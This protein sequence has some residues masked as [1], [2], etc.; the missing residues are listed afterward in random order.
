MPFLPVLHRELIQTARRRHTYRIRVAAALVGIAM[1][2]WLL[3]VSAAQ[4][5]S[6]QQGRVLFSSLSSIAFACS[7]L[8]GIV[9]TADCISVEKR[10]GTLGLLFLTSLRGFDIVLGKLGSFSFTSFY[11]LLSI[12]PILAF[13]VLFGGISSGELIRTAAALL[14][15]LFFSL[16]T[17]LL[18]STLSRNERKAMFAA[19]VMVLAF[20]AGPFLLARQAA[21]LLLANAA[22]PELV[23]PSP[24]FLWLQTRPGTPGMLPPVRHFLGSLLCLHLIAWIELIAAALLLPK[25]CRD[26]PKRAAPWKFWQTRSATTPRQRAW[27][28]RWLDK[29][30]IAWLMVRPALKRISAWLLV[31]SMSGIWVW[32]YWANE[33][34][35]SEGLP[36]LAL[37]ALVQTFVKI[38]IAS[39]VCSRLNEDQ[40]SGTME[41]LLSTP[42]GPV[43][44]ARGVGLAL[45]RIFL[46]VVGALIGAN[47][48][49]VILLPARNSG[50]LPG[51]L[52]Y[53]L[54]FTGVACLLADG[55]AIKWIGMWQ[56]VR[57]A[58]AHRAL[59]R[60]VQEILLLPAL[61]FVG[62]FSLW[63]LSKYLN[64]EPPGA[65]PR[66]WTVSWL[67]LKLA[68]DALLGLRARHLFLTRL[69]AS[70]AGVHDLAGETGLPAPP[71][72]LH[73]ER[74][75]L[76]GRLGRRIRS[77]KLAWGAAGLF[78]IAG[79]LALSSWWHRHRLSQKIGQALEAARSAGYPITD[80]DL[81]RWLPV[82]E[83]GENSVDVLFEAGNNVAPLRYV[84]NWDA[85]EPLFHPGDSEAELKPELDPLVRE[86]LEANRKTVEI[87]HTMVARPKTAFPVVEKKFGSPPSILSSQLFHLT[88]ALQFEFYEA[89]RR[90][91]LDKAVEVIGTL[92]RLGR[93]FGEDP[94]PR[95]FWNRS[96]CFQA[97]SSDLAYLL[98]WTKLTDEMLQSLETQFR[99]SE[100]PQTL[101]KAF[102]VWRYMGVAVFQAG[103]DELGF[104]RSPGGRS[105]AEAVLERWRVLT[106]KD[107]ED[108]LFFLHSA[109][110]TS[111]VAQRPPAERFAAMAAATVKL[112]RSRPNQP[113]V[114]VSW[115]LL[116]MLDRLAQFDASASAHLWMAETA[117]EIEKY[118]RQNRGLPPDN[119]D[120]LSA[121]FKRRGIL[122]DPFNGQGLNFVRRAAGYCLYSVGPDRVDNH[123]RRFVP[124]GG[125]TE[126]DL[127]FEV[128]GS[129]S[130]SSR[131]RN[132]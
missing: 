73:V 66:F 120:Q 44:I 113:G 131:V 61:V 106:G 52:V 127:V 49:F 51:G 33:N 59:L 90:G 86:C 95:L 63:A 50:D 64:Q 31:V 8:A 28:A 129:F 93:C 15:T 107:L 25:I 78:C 122:R 82:A 3:L 79:A 12:L 103:A 14:D 99:K 98:S 121:E 124:F 53:L 85:L 94:R 65:D 89:H 1:M 62:G 56:G 118:R 7:L 87:L 27:R 16:S 34:V 46:P 80:A 110:E 102:T 22:P 42:V 76:M 88:S 123:G 105:L 101:A 30:P 96:N 58:G 18:V 29:S 104:A 45:R 9:A 115:Q 125:R 111:S 114:M 47:V 37:F 13:S 109:E 67:L 5:T 40:R 128:R 112:Q 36:N 91:D 21:R 4:V 100:D 38:W 35:F 23:Y 75:Q 10:Q 54:P 126:S 43:Q 68:S 84:R 92:L 69:R 130:F 108:F 55:F 77:S 71:A 117:L 24:L 48:L 116:P 2:G 57:A 132:D 119:L 19:A 74:A 41:L 17:G 72:E 11:A 26:R 97:A 60:T 20:T 39:E 83:P 81:Q 6:F 70:I 32:I